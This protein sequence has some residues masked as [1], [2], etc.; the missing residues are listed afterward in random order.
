[1]IFARP[2][3][4]SAVQEHRALPMNYRRRAGTVPKA[5]S[6]TCNGAVTAEFHFDPRHSSVSPISALPDRQQP[7]V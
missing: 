6:R 1:M 3:V 2:P 4:P 5:F 7:E